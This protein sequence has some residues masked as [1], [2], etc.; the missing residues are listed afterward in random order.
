[1]EHIWSVLCLHAIEDKHRNNL[2]LIETL[3]QITFHTDKVDV[4]GFQVD[5]YLVSMWWRSN[6]GQPEEGRARLLINS[7][8]AEVLSEANFNIVLTEQSRFKHIIKM[9][10]MPYKGDGI[11]RFVVQLYNK[12]RWKS[13]TTIPLEIHKAATK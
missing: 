11:Y 10:G 6:V 5:L 8:D 3:E 2:S 13:V 7:P 9:H 12:G 1:M 4:E